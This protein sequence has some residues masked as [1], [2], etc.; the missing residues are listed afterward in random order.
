MRRFWFRAAPQKPWLLEHE[1]HSRIPAAKTGG[2][3][4]ETAES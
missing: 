3:S 4:Y 2:F 1:K